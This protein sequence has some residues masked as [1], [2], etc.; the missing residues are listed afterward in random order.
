MNRLSRPAAPHSSWRS[1]DLPARLVMAPPADPLPPGQAQPE[2]G[3]DVGP[4]I[5]QETGLRLA[6]LAE[7]VDGGDLEHAAAAAHHLPQQADGVVAVAIED[8]A[9]VEPR[10]QAAAEGE[11]AREVVVDALRQR[12]ADEDVEGVGRPVARS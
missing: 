3:G 10:Q 1:A 4:E 2:D 9:G 6:A 11:I 8:R 7:A 5:G 12:D